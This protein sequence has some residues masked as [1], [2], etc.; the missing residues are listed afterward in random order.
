MAAAPSTSLA[1]QPRN[2]AAAASSIPGPVAPELLHGAPRGKMDTEASQDVVPD[3]ATETSS[4]P[5]E[6]AQREDT[7]VSK[8]DDQSNAMDVVTGS[9]KRALEDP[10]S[11]RGE[12]QLRRVER[13]WCGKVGRFKTQSAPLTR[14]K[15]QMQ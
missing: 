11:G 9:A 10:P 6:T 3:Q 13:E 1:Q 4:T 15:E 8:D 14:N 12:A 7:V 2:E 5:A